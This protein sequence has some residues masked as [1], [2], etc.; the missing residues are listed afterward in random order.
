[1]KMKVRQLPRMELQEQK[2]VAA[3]IKAS[4][5]V[6]LL[7]WLW[8]L[9]M[10]VCCCYFILFK[11]MEHKAIGKEEDTVSNVGSHKLHIFKDNFE[12]F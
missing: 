12:Q 4:I 8:G 9:R 5:L 6:V 11:L 7:A 3:C 2:G 10:D 1:M